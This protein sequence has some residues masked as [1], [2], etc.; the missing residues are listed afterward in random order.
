M[1]ELLEALWAEP[2]ALQGCRASKHLAYFG[3]EFVGILHI[4]RKGLKE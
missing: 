4:D 1:P 3:I 2:I